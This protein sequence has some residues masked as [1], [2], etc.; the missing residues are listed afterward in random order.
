MSVDV[1]ITGDCLFL[2]YARRTYAFVVSAISR[3]SVLFTLVSEL[4]GVRFLGLL[5]LMACNVLYAP[6]FS[7]FVVFPA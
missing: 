6:S 1:D 5:V 7:H 3:G 2:S 4:S